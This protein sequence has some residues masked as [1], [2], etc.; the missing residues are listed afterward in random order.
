MT[1]RKELTNA[2]PRGRH[3]TPRTAG[4]AG[5]RGTGARGGAEGPAGGR[6]ASPRRGRLRRALPYA[7]LA[8]GLA[9]LLWFPV[10]EGIDAWRRS[11]VAASL[12]AA[13]AAMGDGAKAEL[14][15]QARAY[16]RRLA[17]LT[18]GIPS[19]EILPYAEQLSP[20]GHD[21]A[22]A[23]LVA[24]TIGLT[25]P[26]YHGTGE[27]ALSAGAGHLETSSLPVGGD[28]THAVV[29]AHSGMAGMRAFDDIRLLEPGEVFAVSVLGDLYCYEVTGTETVLPEQAESLAI[30]AGEDL[31]TLVTCTPYGVNTHR[32]LVHA[33]RCAEPEGFLGGHPSLARVASSRRVWPA[34]AGLVAAGAV[35]ATGGALARRRRGRAE[36]DGPEAGAAPATAP[37]GPGPTTPTD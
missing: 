23:Y 21:T 22:F 30:R 3:F 8:L 32:L 6:A 13:A 12:D 37:E 11:Q 34:A 35:A 18:P 9:V 19:D 36:G 4:G 24:P 2:S 17:G 27:A 31:C 33:R 20:D 14:L 15:A 10:T 16:N 25:V 1:D 7:G 5:G 28:A 29:T 26:V